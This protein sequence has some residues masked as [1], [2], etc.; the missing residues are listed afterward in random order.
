M[1]CLTLL[2]CWSCLCCWSQCIWNLSL[3]A[4]LTVGEAAVYSGWEQIHSVVRHVKAKD[5]LGGL[6]R[7]RWDHTRVFPPA[8]LNPYKHSLLQREQVLQA[9]PRG[10]TLNSGTLTDLQHQHFAAFE[11]PTNS[12]P[13]MSHRVFSQNGEMFNVHSDQLCYFTRWH[14]LENTVS[15][16]YYTVYDI[17][18]LYISYSMY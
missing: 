10:Q 3:K 15:S 14:I 16:L 8:T 18:H 11:K 17:F 9:S 6:D 5:V 4:V 1:L 12:N 2:F 13:T 7:M